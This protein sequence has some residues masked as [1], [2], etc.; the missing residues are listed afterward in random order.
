M[1]EG[2]SK[3]LSVEDLAAIIV[4]LNSIKTAIDDIEVKIDAVKTDGSISVD[5]IDRWARQLG[6]IDLF[7]YM[8]APVGPANPVDVDVQNWPADYP[9]AAAFALLAML[10]GA[11]DSVGTDKLHVKSEMLIQS[12]YDRVCTRDANGRLTQVVITSGLRTK[13]VDIARDADGRWNAINETVT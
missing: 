4:V 10:T 5:V 12:E 8:G 6:Q 2:Q 7:R 1:A 11:L 13:T 9:D 3:F